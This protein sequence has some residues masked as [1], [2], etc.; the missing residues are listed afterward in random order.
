M[1]EIPLNWVVKEWNKK[2]ISS[3][4]LPRAGRLWKVPD[5]SQ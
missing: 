4:Q 5:A 2:D 1:D 3:P